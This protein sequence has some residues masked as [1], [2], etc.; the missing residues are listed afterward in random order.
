MSTA[1]EAIFAN[2]LGLE[3]LGISCVTNIAAGLTSNKLSQDE[4]LE[5]GNRVA[6]QFTKFLGNLLPK[7]I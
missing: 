4:V 3:V 2:Y 5:A 7:L 6:A 1:A